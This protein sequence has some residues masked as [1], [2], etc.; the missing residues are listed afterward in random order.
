V[1][2]LVA[3]VCAGCSR[4]TVV[5]SGGVEFPDTAKVEK[6]DIVQIVFVPEDKEEK[7]TPLATFSREDKRFQCKDILP[8]AK[9]KIAVRIEPSISA[10]D[11]Q[12]RVTAM[13]DF[14][15][16]FDRASTK[17]TYLASEESSQSITLDLAKGTVTKQ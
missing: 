9:Y 13:R 4:R 11:A 1:G 12:K 5:V 17:L 14:N 6:D 16:K 8:G 10:P 15:K 3:L 2:V 7:K